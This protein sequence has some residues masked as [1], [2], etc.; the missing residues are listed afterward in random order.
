ME[1]HDKEEMDFPNKFW[2]E[3]IVET[4]TSAAPPSPSI[5][6]DG[7]KSIC[8]LSRPAMISFPPTKNT[9]YGPILSPTRQTA[10]AS[11]AQDQHRLHPERRMT[12]HGEEDV[13]HA[14]FGM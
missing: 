10:L 3:R 9:G 4:T 5:G 12:E 13:G 8:L 11:V 2:T 14:E 7:R 1:G 6:T